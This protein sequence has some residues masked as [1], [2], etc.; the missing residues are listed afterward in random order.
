MMKGDPS[1]SVSL[2]SP[3][4]STMNLSPAE[5]LDKF[6]PHQ[7]MDLCRLGKIDPESAAAALE[8]Y[9]RKP[10]RVFRRFLVALKETVFGRP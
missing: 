7:I 6:T 5:L 9:D 1:M 4:V 3:P 8:L 10:S 2:E